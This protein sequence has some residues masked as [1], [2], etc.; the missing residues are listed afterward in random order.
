MLISEVKQV[1][2]WDGGDRHNFGF[3][4]RAEVADKDIQDR[5]PHCSIM[6]KTL[7]VFETLDEVE[8]NS[9]KELRRKVWAKLSPLERAAIGMKE[10]PK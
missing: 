6:R 4:I 10:E 7:C 5:H 2:L 3:F 8:A 1:D 9:V